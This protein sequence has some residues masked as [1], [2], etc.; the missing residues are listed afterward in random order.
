MTLQCLRKCTRSSLCLLVLDIGKW[1]KSYERLIGRPK[2]VLNSYAIKRKPI[3][4]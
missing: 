3:E 1:R 2:G 4:D